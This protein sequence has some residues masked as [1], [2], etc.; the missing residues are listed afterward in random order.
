MV[1]LRSFY[2]ILF[3]FFT[4]AC[5]K[6]NE[7]LTLPENLDIVTAKGSSNEICFDCDNQV[8]VY[9]NYDKLML[10]PFS[11]VFRWDETKEKY[12]EITFIFYFT[13]KDKETLKKELEKMSFHYPVLHDPT[14]SFYKTNHLDTTSLNNKHFMAYILKHQRA[15]SLA[16]LGMVD[17]FHEQLDK[18]VAK[19]ALSMEGVN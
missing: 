19:E 2:L 7:P 10:V 16:N 18:I 17:L 13:G 15:K 6:A 5:K 11:K 9:F 4:I 14:N 12:P 3:M 1:F 8:V